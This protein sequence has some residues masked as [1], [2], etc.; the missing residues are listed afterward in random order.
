MAQS[1]ATASNVA[2]GNAVPVSEVG[3][4]A[5]DAQGRLAGSFTR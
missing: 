2:S 1:N 3:V 4:R 5:Y